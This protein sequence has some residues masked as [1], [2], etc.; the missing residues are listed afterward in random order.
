MRF[1]IAD[2]PF[3]Q[4][5]HEKSSGTR[6]G[7]F[8]QVNTRLTPMLLFLHFMVLT[9]KKT[10]PQKTQTLSVFGGENMINY[11]TVDEEQI[12]VVAPEVLLLL[13]AE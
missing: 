6:M 9:Q 11:Q 10:K 3:T 12:G 13:L 5:S 2:V 7:V 1:S 4:T 8:L